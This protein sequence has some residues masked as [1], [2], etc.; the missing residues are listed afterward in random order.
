M[1]DSSKQML[2]EFANVIG[3][4]EI[5]QSQM[6]YH[7]TSCGSFEF[8]SQV[9]LHSARQEHSQGKSTVA[10]I[11]IGNDLDEFCHQLFIVALIKCIDEYGHGC[12][13]GIGVS[14]RKNGFDHQFL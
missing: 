1:V 9:F 14:H 4:V 5:L 11:C 13:C 2:K 6:I 12:R 8:L 7:R 3:S 10:L